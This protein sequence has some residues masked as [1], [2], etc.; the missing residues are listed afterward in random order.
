M[1][2]ALYPIDEIGCKDQ[3]KKEEVG[4]VSLFNDISSFMGHLMPKPSF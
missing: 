4:L 3:E 2:L 1:H